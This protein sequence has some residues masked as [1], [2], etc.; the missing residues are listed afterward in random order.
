M[1][2]YKFHKY[3]LILIILLVAGL[4][5]YILFIHQPGSSTKNIC[6]IV[7]ISID[8]CRSDYLS[9]Y[10]CPMKTTPHIDDLA[11]ESIL[12][13][14]VI[15][16]VPITLPAHSSMLTGTIPPYHGV[17]NN[18]GYTL[19]PSNLTL[20]EILDKKGF[21]SAALVGSF[22]L[23]AQ[24]GLNQGF[25][26]YNDSFED[27]VHGAFGDERQAGEISRLAS[28][29]LDKHQEDNFFLFLHYYDPHA[30]YNP[31]EPF[32]TNFRDNLYAGEIA[33]TDHCIGQVIDKLKELD[34]Y[35]SSLIVITG[36]HGE[37]LGEH[38]ENTHTYFIYQSALK[39]P[40]IF[41]LPG[42]HPPQKVDD[43]VGL[44][45]IVPTICSL[46]GIDTQVKMQGIDLSPYFHPN[47]PAMS[48]RHIYCESVTAAVAFRAN[49]LLGLVTD[50]W[51][52][53]Q[54]TRPEL[55][56]IIQDPGEKNNLAMQH[57][58][59][60]RVLQDHLKQMLENT[61]QEFES[62][63][64]KEFDWKD[65]RR[66]QS[67]GY[68]AGVANTDFT[69]DQ[70]KT[71]PKDL[72]DHYNSY[73]EFLKLAW[74]KN[75]DQAKKLCA[76]LISQD[77]QLIETNLFMAVDALGRQD[78]AQ[79]IPCL[80]NLLNLD[81]DLFK[82]H[83]NLATSYSRLNQPAQAIKH[84]YEALKIKPDT[85]KTHNELAE[86]LVQQNELDKAIFHYEKS[87]EIESS[88]TVILGKLAEL[89]SQKDN[90]EKVIECWEKALHL[91]PQW[92][93]ALN[94]LAWIL[95][96]HENEAIRNPARAVELAQQACD[97]TKNT[98]LSTLDTLA[99]AYA[100]AENYPQAIKTAEKILELA[101][102]TGQGDFEAKAKQRL[103]LFN[104][105]IQ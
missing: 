59:Q 77:P 76:K 83:Y 8:T 79:A 60:A 92:P 18:L 5:V 17:R 9:C 84:Y 11:A 93:T 2:L 26:T 80:E 90:T 89:Y 21:T 67:L 91:N 103:E 61:T 65:I 88:Q 48:D 43:L 42:N 94:N 53:I 33:Y 37:M 95:A 12:F 16:P 22:V 39:V 75:N 38:D 50:R 44:I 69:F 4:S 36:D 56:D 24:F 101:R 19:G 25:D 29:W 10:G 57:P 7:L 6:H 30:D 72:L 45:D 81:Y 49:T 82:T 104:A 54:T 28:D 66:L 62:E 41:K 31:P 52:Y 40:L 1:K 51:K 15:S 99:V 32:A 34:I 98:N 102:A 63:S 74:D 100:A 47:Q 97:L 55:Y 70:S 96:T 58:R 46:L 3:L 27:V 64:K 85:S 78:Y 71:D 20:P 105:H 35:D 13:S 87:L 14:N 23:D 73:M 86:V 68:V